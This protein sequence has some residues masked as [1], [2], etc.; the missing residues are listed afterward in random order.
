MFY[1]KG[2]PNRIRPWQYKQA[3]EKCGWTNISIT[4]GHTLEQRDNG[5]C[6]RFRD[7]VNQMDY[8]S[9]WLCATKAG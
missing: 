7:D 4:P 8:L 6:R 1:F 5:Y 3:F 9:F 2:M